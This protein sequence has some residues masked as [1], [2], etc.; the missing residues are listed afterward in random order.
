[1][2]RRSKR[3]RIALLAAAALLAAL[4][5]D[6]RFRLVTTG[7]ELRFASLPPAFDGFRVVQLSDLHGACFGRENARLLRA[8]RAEEPDLIALTGDLV[9]SRS[10]LAQ[11]EALLT[12]LTEIAPVCY[13]SGN[14]EWSERLLPRLTP[15]LARCGVRYLRNESVEL[16]R[17]G[18]RIVLAGVED[19]NGPLDMPRPDEVI[20]QCRETHPD[21]FLLLLGHRNDWIE[22]YPDLDADLVLCGHAHGGVVRIPGVGGL[23]GTDRRLFPE[24][25]E[26][27]HD[28]G[29]YRLVISRGLGSGAR[30]PRLFNNPELVCVTL[31]SA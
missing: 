17:G 4:L 8:V 9:D 26:G 6:S 28:S 12:R 22:R 20:A 31:R 1:M 27:V 3:R 25:T 24:H 23:L 29:R 10:D 2:K 16:A 19:P 15:I 30:I 7:Y 21:D 14:H 11:T 5:L 13:V 18:A